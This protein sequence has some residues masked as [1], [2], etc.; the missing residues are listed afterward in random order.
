MEG[1]F[2]GFGGFID[3][4]NPASR[5]NQIVFLV[6]LVV[7]VFTGTALW[8]CGNRWIRLVCLLINQVFSMGILLSWAQIVVPAYILWREALVVMVLT[9]L[10]ACFLFR[11]RR[12]KVVPEKRGRVPREAR[13]GEVG[14]TELNRLS[15]EW[16]AEAAAREQ[17]MAAHPRPIEGRGLASSPPESPSHP[18]GSSRRRR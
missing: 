2:S 13:R 6:W 11:K 10:L 5:N 7:T 1:L 15:E 18:S 17:D 8:R 16:A 9:I 14:A 3:Q 12:P 4:L